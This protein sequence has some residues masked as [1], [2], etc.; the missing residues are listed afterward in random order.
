MRLF[1]FKIYYID[2]SNPKDTIHEQGF[3]S[4]ATHKDAV[5]NISNFYGDEYIIELTITE[6]ENLIRVPKDIHTKIEE[7][8]FLIDELSWQ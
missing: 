5:A 2:E 7:D 6:L 1:S 3:T 4:A 8:E